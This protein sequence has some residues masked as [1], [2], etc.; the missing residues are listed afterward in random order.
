[1]ETNIV[2]ACIAASNFG[3]EKYRRAG[4]ILTRFDDEATGEVGNTER[5]YRGLVLKLTHEPESM[6]LAELIALRA[7]IAAYADDGNRKAQV[8]SDRGQPQDAALIQHAL[9]DVYAA[10]SVLEAMIDVARAQTPV[11]A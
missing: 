3:A 11:A 4:A 6:T 2:N 5:L 9:R 10:L 8:L 7:A 1:M